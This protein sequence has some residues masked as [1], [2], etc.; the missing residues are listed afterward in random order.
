MRHRLIVIA[1]LSLSSSLAAQPVAVGAKV[2]VDHSRGRTEG[3]LIRFNSQ[4]VV[5]RRGNVERTIPRAEIKTMFGRTSA[6]VPGALLV[7]IPSALLMG[8]VGHGMSKAYCQPSSDCASEAAGAFRQGALA[9]GLVGAGVGGVIGAVVGRWSPVF[10][11][12]G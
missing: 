11:N 2:R 6:A 7:G 1:I 9:G 3:L 10:R 4:S 8:A 5:V 12:D